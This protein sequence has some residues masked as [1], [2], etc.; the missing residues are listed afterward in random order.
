MRTGFAIFNAAQ[1][2][3]LFR[4]DGVSHL[5]VTVLFL[6]ERIRFSINNGMIPRSVLFSS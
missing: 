2:R 1:H 6:T 3:D 5:S 4:P